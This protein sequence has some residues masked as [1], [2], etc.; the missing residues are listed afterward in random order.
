MG[1]FYHKIITPQIQ[2]TPEHP[3]GIPVLPLGSVLE[4]LKATQTCPGETFVVLPYKLSIN[5]VGDDG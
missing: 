4:P 2:E 3:V 1:T 5:S